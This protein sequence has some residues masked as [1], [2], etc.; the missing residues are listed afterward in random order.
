MD[1]SA[2]AADIAVEAAKNGLTIDA[3]AIISRGHKRVETIAAG[4]YQYV[5]FETFTGKCAATGGCTAG[6]RYVLSGYARLSDI[7]E[8]A[9]PERSRR[10]VTSL[11][12]EKK[13]KRGEEA[14]REVSQEGHGRCRLRESPGGTRRPRRP[15]R[16]SLPS[17]PSCQVGRARQKLIERGS[18][19]SGSIA[20]SLHRS[21]TRNKRRTRTSPC[22]NKE[23]ALHE[24]VMGWKLRF[25]PG[26]RPS[27]W[28]KYRR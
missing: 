16:R 24:E 18:I 27:Y 25:R 28:P 9:A 14:E 2:I 22:K 20:K 26:Y 5:E 19:D 21:P 8:A 1:L 7:A 10:S 17:R 3:D 13:G 6:T 15:G 4:G 12:L 11:L 23:E